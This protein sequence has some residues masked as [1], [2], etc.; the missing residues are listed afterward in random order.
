MFKFSKLYL[1][2]AIALGIYPTF[3]GLAVNAQDRGPV[4]IESDYPNSNNPAPSTF[5]QTT[6]QAPRQIPSAPQNVDIQR[7]DNPSIS[8]TR[9][10]CQYRDGRNL[11]MYQPRS[12][13][14]QLFA[15]ASP[16]N[17]GG[18][19]SN[20]KR[21]NEISR[22]L[23][24]YRPDGLVEM[25]TSTE[26]GYNIICATTE[27]NPACRIILTVPVG[28]DPN[29]IRDRVFAN[30]S[31]ADSGQTTAPVNTLV[32]RSG[33]SANGLL[34]ILGIPTNSPSPSTY[35]RQGIDLKPFL[36]R[37]DGGSGR[38]LTNGYSAEPGSRLAP[39]NFR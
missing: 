16:A 38:G 24:Q 20:E 5:P 15:W 36:D 25:R 7:S 39:G 28:S 2:L 29:T 1:G 12:Q 9:F 37:A 23:E 8:S 22:R 4:P 33:N 3:L 10:S 31:T 27:Q 30:L 11:V 18:G 21:C 32:G 14:G 6:R 34:G 19:W 26:N 17:M 35:R 13:P